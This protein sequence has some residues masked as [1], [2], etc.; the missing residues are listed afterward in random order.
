MRH[1]IEFLLLVSQ[2]LV[3]GLH[4]RLREESGLVKASLRNMLPFVDRFR[5]RKYPRDHFDLAA[6]RVDDI[7]AFVRKHAAEFGTP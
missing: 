4:C 6:L 1:T 3:A 5:E 7:G 2:F